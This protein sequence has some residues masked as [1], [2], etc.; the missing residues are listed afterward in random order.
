[1]KEKFDLTSILADAEKDD[2]AERP[3]HVIIS[4]DD[5]DGLLKKTGG[6]RRADKEV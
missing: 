5:I 3:E 2:A 4:Q 6:A 1:M